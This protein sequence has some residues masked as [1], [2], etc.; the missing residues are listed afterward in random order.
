MISSSND[1]DDS[2]KSHR[3]G[4]FAKSNA[5]YRTT[6]METQHLHTERRDSQMLVNKGKPSS[7]VA[8]VLSLCN[9]LIASC[10]SLSIICSFG[11]AHRQQIQLLQSPMRITRQWKCEQHNWQIVFIIYIKQTPSTATYYVRSKP[12]TYYFLYDA[13]KFDA[14]HSMLCE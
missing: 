1:F 9:F 3:R 7:F 10:D 8:F 4:W 13:Q 14:R 12:A 5:I 6:I 2:V 11:M